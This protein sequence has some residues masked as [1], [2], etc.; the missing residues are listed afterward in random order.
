MK[1]IDDKLEHILGYRFE[2]VDNKIWFSNKD[3]EGVMLNDWDKA[4]LR[5]LLDKFWGE[6]Y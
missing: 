4:Q 1:A 6:V 3:H 2:V 5:A